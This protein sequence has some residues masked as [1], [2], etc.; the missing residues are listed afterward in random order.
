MKA[1]C[2]GKGFHFPVSSQKTIDNSVLELDYNS[3]P[4]ICFHVSTLPP[5]LLLWKFLERKAQILFILLCFPVCRAVFVPTRYLINGTNNNNNKLINV[6]IKNGYESTF[7]IEVLMKNSANESSQDP[8]KYRFWFRKFG[9]GPE[10]L[11]CKVPS[12]ELSQAHF[13]LQLL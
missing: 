9:V 3:Y 13:R 6:C 10:S 4:Q 5:T 11:N 1:G 2:R 12:Q 8:I 7:T